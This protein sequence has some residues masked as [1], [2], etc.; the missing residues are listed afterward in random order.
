MVTVFIP[1][2]VLNSDNINFDNDNSK[3]KGTDNIMVFRQFLKQYQKKFAI[4]SEV[5]TTIVK[6]D[7]VEK[8]KNRFWN[9]NEEVTTRFHRNNNTDNDII[10]NDYFYRLNVSINFL[11][12]K[13]GQQRRYVTVKNGYDDRI[14]DFI[15]I[16]MTILNWEN[17]SKDDELFISNQWQDADNM[18]QIWRK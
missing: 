17:E 14:H 3:N 2:E 16:F 7:N 4:I 6:W 5:L 15:V 8:T 11:R 10:T 9:I 1:T 18:K 13:W 12:L